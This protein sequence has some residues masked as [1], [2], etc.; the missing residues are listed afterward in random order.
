MSIYYEP[1]GHAGANRIIPIGDRHVP[2]PSH[3]RQ[4]LGDPRGRWEGSTLVVE[5]TNFTNKTAY[6]ESCENLHLTERFTRIDGETVRYKVTVQD[7]TTWTRPWTIRADVAKQN[8]YETRLYEPSCH[9]GN[10]GI[11]GILSGARTEEREFAEGR[12]PDPDTKY[13][14]Y[15]GVPGISGE[16]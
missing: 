15:R 13:T 1:S 14:L 5:T 2:L 10:Y 6:R 12:G 11:V 7:P 16:P 3:I 9:E 8:E 4:W